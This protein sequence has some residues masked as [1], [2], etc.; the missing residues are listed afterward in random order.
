LFSGDHLIGYANIMPLESKAWMRALRGELQDGLVTEDDIR[1]FELPGLYGVYVCCVAILAEY[2]KFPAAFGTLYD[3]VFDKFFWL[4]ENEIYVSEMAANAWTAE[5]KPLSESFGMKAVCNHQRH[6]EVFHCTLIPP[7][8]RG[9]SRKL[10]MLL[11]KYRE[12]GLVE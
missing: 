4:A 6:G 5:G 2:R 1:R 10:R 8:T 3:K 12:V 9:H 11:G 7:E